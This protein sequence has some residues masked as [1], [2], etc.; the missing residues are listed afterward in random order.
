MSYHGARNARSS[1]RWFAFGKDE[2]LQFRSTMKDRSEGTFDFVQMNYNL[3]PIETRYYNFCIDEEDMRAQNLPV[4]DG[5]TL[6]GFEP[7]I[8]SKWVHHYTLF[9]SNDGCGFHRSAAMDQLYSWS[10][11]K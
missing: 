3:L 8:T 10:P 4:D 11:G 9:G 6:V 5:F 2:L 7:I 1:L